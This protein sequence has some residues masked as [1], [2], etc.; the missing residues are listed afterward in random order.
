MRIYLK[1]TLLF[2][3]ILLTLGCVEQPVE[4]VLEAAKPEPLSFPETKEISPVDIKINFKTIP[5][6]VI[7]GDVIELRWEIVSG[8]PLTFPHTAVH[9]DSKTHPGD[10]ST[11]IGP[12]ESGY[13]SLTTKYASGKFV[14]PDKFADQIVAP[15]GTKE[16][17]LRAHVI[18]DGKNYW[19]TEKVIQIVQ[20]S[21]PEVVIPVKEFTIE[22]DDSGFYPNSITVKKDDLV[23][24]KFVT[25]T[26]NVYYG[27]LDFRGKPW[28]TTG[29]VKPGE[30]MTVQ[31]T[32]TD[33][34]EFKS[35]WPLTSALKATGKVIVE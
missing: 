6:R 7:A 11:E 1:F 17:F 28:E 29:K 3:L 14:V 13:P 30:N 26:K 18:I 10:F 4:E 34:F 35:Y 27:G 21:P 19:T 20:P 16:L 2:S 23:K 15:P 31:F 5:S 24:I 33:T 9:Y 25:R 32:A 12:Q 22:G 8:V